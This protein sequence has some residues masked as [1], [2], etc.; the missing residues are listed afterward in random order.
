ML[1]VVFHR[2][3]VF[4]KVGKERF[5]AFVFQSAPEKHRNELSPAGLFPEKRGKLFPADLLPREIPFQKRVVGR[6]EGFPDAFVRQG[7]RP[8]LHSRVSFRNHLGERK[9]RTV[10]AVPELLEDPGRVASRAVQL[11]EKKDDGRAGF[12]E[13]VP[14]DPGLGARAVGRRDDQDPEIQD[15]KRSFHLRGEIH[16]PRRVDEIDA[17][18]SA[19]QR[20]RSGLHRDP[21]L[22]LHRHGVGTGGPLVHLS[23]SA[24]RARGI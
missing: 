4:R 24:H 18:P 5:H 1:E 2:L 7:Q 16:V 14:Q 3:G 8:R 10:Q 6:D 23:P 22:P 12:H 20:D 15:R 17:R 19:D 11:V 13:G 9:K 21:P